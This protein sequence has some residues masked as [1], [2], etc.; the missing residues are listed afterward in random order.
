MSN[1]QSK[2]ANFKIKL[3]IILILLVIGGIIS[4]SLITA[5]GVR[6]MT[7]LSYDNEQKKSAAMMTDIRGGFLQSDMFVYRLFLQSATEIEWKDGVSPQDQLLLVAK[8]TNEKYGLDAEYFFMFKDSEMLAAI[9]GYELEPVDPEELRARIHEKIESDPEGY[10]YVYDE[11]TEK[12]VLKAAK[13]QGAIDA[14]DS[15]IKGSAVMTIQ[16]YVDGFYLGI[17]TDESMAKLWEDRVDEIKNEYDTE[18]RLKTKKALRSIVLNIIIAYVIIGLVA[19]LAALK[20]VSSVATPVEKDSIEKEKLL[21]LSQME[22]EAL[23]EA[24]RLKS[25][26]LANISHELKT[27]LTIVSGYADESRE[28]LMSIPSENDLMQV[29]KNIKVIIAEAN[30]LALM[31]SQVMDVSA[32]D[33]G[34]FNLNKK[35]VSPTVLIQDILNTYYPVFANNGNT[36]NYM[37]RSSVSSVFCDENRIRQVIINLITNASRHTRNGNITVMTEDE[38]DGIKISVKDTGEGISEEALPYIFERYYKD[39]EGGNGKRNTGTGLGLYISKCIIE[40]HGGTIGIESKLGEGT[41]IS[42]VIPVK[43]ELSETYIS[44]PV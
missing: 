1:T 26:S 27:P 7:D 8:Q 18:N 30:R 38:K 11:Y 28:L 20:V 40:A 22:K 13:E 21:R 16:E 35:N 6:Y 42:F 3:Y 14:F 2:T 24:D 34:R 5:Y 4:S 10:G 39:E 43:N 31:V 25:E 29:E 32:I 15:D 17:Y 19:G 37:K 33:E 12:D 23:A 44:S 41:T 36:V 9:K